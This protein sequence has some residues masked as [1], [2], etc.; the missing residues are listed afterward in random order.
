M[1]IIFFVSMSAVMLLVTIMLSPNDHDYYNIT[2]CS[3]QY[4]VFMAHIY[5]TISKEI[6]MYHTRS[7]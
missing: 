4:L 6:D 5:G 1:I 7:I 3:I 2:G